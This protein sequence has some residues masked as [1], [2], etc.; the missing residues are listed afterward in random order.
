MKGVRLPGAAGGVGV[1]QS[2]KE[3][4]SE[5]GALENLSLEGSQRMRVGKKGKRN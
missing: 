4:G 5:E 3:E 1:V 2:E